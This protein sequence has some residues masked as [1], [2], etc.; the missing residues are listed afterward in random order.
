M[1][2]KSFK[3][4]SY[5]RK[6]A[7]VK[8]YGASRGE[9]LNREAEAL[10]SNV[11]RAYRELLGQ[12]AD[13]LVGAL[14]TVLD[15][16]VAAYVRRKKEAAVL[17]FDDLLVMAHELVC[18]HEPVRAAVGRRFQHVFVDEFQDTD[19]VQAAIIFSIAAEAAPKRW[20]D[21][22]LRRCVY[23]KPYPDFSGNR[24]G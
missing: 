8:K 19:R 4:G 9:A 7:W 17:D 10:F 13:G 22:L 18:P 21:T 14:S 16:V 1:E 15:D 6:T 11:E 5:R 24:I 23:R 20:Q 3:L 12:I 2:K